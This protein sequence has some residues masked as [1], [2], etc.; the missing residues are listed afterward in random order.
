MDDNPTITKRRYW[1][2]YLDIPVF[3]TYTIGEEVLNKKESQKL[4]EIISANL[5]DADLIL[6][7]DYGH[8]L[9]NDRMTDAVSKRI[10]RPTT[11]CNA[12]SR[13]WLCQRGEP[14]LYVAAATPARG[15]DGLLATAR[16]TPSR[17]GTNNLTLSCSVLM[18]R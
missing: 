10:T 6:V 7:A 16:P 14:Q 17:W 2:R 3:E 5:P 15:V 11:R 8:G 1:D 18:V 13:F 9:I 12:G 4:E